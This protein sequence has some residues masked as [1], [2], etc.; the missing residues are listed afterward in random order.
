MCV[1]P[2]GGMCG[3]P[4]A[5]YFSHNL[6]C[7]FIAR[8]Y[9]DLSSKH[10]NPELGVLVRGWNPSLFRT[11]SELEIS[12]P[13]HRQV[14]EL[15]FPIS[16]IPTSLDVVSSLFLSYRISVQLDFRGF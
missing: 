13:H 15:P 12:L 4:E 8:N 14:W 5:L 3:T 1:G 7:F 9:G 6:C 2:L 16:T 11:S 10:W